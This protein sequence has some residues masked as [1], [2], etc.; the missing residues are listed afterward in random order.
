MSG[1]HQA[2]AQ[3]AQGVG[4]TGAGQSEGQDVDAVF[5]DAALG[6][7]VQLLA[8]RQG[9]AVMLEG[10]P[11]LAR[12]EQ[13]RLTQPVDAPLAAVRGF[14]LQ[15]LKQGGQGITASTL[16]ETQGGL[17]RYCG[18]L[19]LMAQLADAL[20]HD[21][22]NRARSIGFLPSGRPTTQAVVRRKVAM[23][24]QCGDQRAGLLL[25]QL[26]EANGRAGPAT[27]DHG[28]SGVGVGQ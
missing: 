5:D 23:A 14:L 10:L 2:V 8:E 3:G 7:M 28:P 16:G 13:G 21:A 15:H 9:H 11:G 1:F 17:R 12:G 24:M 19:E 27:L 25:V 20:L 26:V 18:Q 4:L 22:G 6:Q